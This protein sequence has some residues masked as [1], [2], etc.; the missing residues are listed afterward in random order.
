MS[1]DHYSRDNF[2]GT[3]LENIPAPSNNLGK[4]YLN[5]LRFLH[6]RNILQADTKLFKPPSNFTDDNLEHSS[7]SLNVLTHL[8]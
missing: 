3:Y 8:E 5:S 2:K 1:I 7:Y 4:V 6:P